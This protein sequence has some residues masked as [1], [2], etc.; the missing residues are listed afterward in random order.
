MHVC[1]V[2]N[3]LRLHS[4]YA[5]VEKC[6]FE[7]LTIQF[8]G[9]VISPTGIE[10]DPKKVSAILDWPTPLDKKGVQRFIGF[11]NFYRKFI[12][13]FSTIVAPITQLTKQNLRF[14]WNPE[15]QKAFDTLKGLFTSAPILSHP[16]PALPFL[17]EIDASEVAV[18]AVISQRSGDKDLMLPVGFYSRKHSS[19]EKNYDVGDRELLAIKTALEEWKT[20]T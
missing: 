20:I 14:R 15:A 1:K 19:T 12:K 8:L 6:E 18:G 11:A 3:R 5:K 10:M 17:L 2:L 13:N 7:R 16:N 4:L 9:L